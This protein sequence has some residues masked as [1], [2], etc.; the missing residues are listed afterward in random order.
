LSD[1]ASQRH[2]VRQP[3][4]PT[5]TTVLTELKAIAPESF[6]TGSVSGSTRR[7]RLIF[8]LPLVLTD[9]GVLQQEL[10]AARH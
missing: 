7:A 10:G 8:L 2:P 4:L 6:V 3:R 5:A 9:R 1:H